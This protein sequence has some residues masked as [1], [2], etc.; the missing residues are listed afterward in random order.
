MQFREYL[1]LHRGLRAALLSVC[2]LIASF[3]LYFEIAMYVLNLGSPGIHYTLS[4]R[5][6]VIVPILLFAV[7][8]N[9]AVAWIL[10]K[11]DRRN[12]WAMFALGLGVIIVGAILASI[13]IW[14]EHWIDFVKD[15]LGF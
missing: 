10:H 4:D 2:F 3:T 9:A 11:P 12:F 5:L 8:L 15:L 1:E 13:I 7:V 6:L 14:R